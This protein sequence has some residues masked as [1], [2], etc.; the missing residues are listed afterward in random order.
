MILIFSGFFISIIILAISASLYEYYKED[1]KNEWIIA[2]SLIK[3]TK[4]LLSL[5]RD[6]NDIACVHGIRAV[7]A[8]LLII[9]HKS[10]ALFF[11]PYANRTAMAETVGQ[12]WTVIARAASLYTDPFIMMSGLLTTY[13][14]VGR[15]QKG[16]TIRITQEYIGRF[17]RIAP[18]LGALILFC[19]Y[20]LP[21][22]GSGPQWN[23][24]ITHHSG[25]CKMY[26]WRNLMFIH[27]Y[28]GFENMVRIVLSAQYLTF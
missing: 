23:L 22:M 8:Y 24:V 3:N 2:F 19:T 1:N 13:S 14:L 28:F 16:Q 18:P 27:N 6:A 25:I 21:L 12:P 5:K 4:N 10:M 7:N 20:V 15:L 11:N 17:F 26:W 9:S